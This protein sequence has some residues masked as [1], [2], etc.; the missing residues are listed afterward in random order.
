VSVCVC[1]CV[2]CVCN[3]HDFGIKSN[4][5]L[6]SLPFV[7]AFLHH[8]APVAPAPFQINF[9]DEKMENILI[10]SL[11]RAGGSDTAKSSR[12]ASCSHQSESN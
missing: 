6:Q 11:E 4:L 9:R 2:V 7:Y 1:V 5:D 3:K 10:T 12:P 8:A